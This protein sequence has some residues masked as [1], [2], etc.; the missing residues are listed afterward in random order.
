MG[1]KLLHR[2]R[3][4]EPQT[5]KRSLRLVLAMLLWPQ[6]CGAQAMPD[7]FVHLKS[8]DP[9]ILQD[10]RYAGRFN[11]L[12]APAP[13]YDAAE[14]ILHRRAAEALARAQAKAKA[15]GLSLKVLDCYRPQKATQAFAA[16]VRG[17]ETGEAARDFHPGMSKKHLIERKFI[18]G[19][20]SHSLGLAVDVTLVGLKHS[21]AQTKAP[22]GGPCNGPFDT[23]PLES[24]LD[25]GTTF[26]CFAE[27]SATDHKA[28]PDEARRNRNLLRTIMKSGGFDNYAREWWHYH[29]SPAPKGVTPQNFDIINR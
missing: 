24:D 7:D 19:N 16:W 20:S 27:E 1:F 25:F 28:L 5:M 13:G 8:V 29:L 21:P 14:C 9:S 3:A 2:R 10:I 26:D 6:P 23:R 17:P 22:G 15:E 4:I 18:S 12:G 11:F